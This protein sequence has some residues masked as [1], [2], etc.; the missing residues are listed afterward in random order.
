MTAIKLELNYRAYPRKFTQ[1]QDIIQKDQDKLKEIDS[2]IR[3]KGPRISAIMELLT[4]L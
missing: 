3:F 1:V 2:S 4:N